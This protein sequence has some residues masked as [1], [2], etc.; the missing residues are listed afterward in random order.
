MRKL[1]FHKHHGKIKL[2]SKSETGDQIGTTFLLKLH[3]QIWWA[4]L[5]GPFEAPCILMGFQT[6][7]IE[8]NLKHSPL[9]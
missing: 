7:E 9:V 5:G 4:M 1:Q 8:T 2:H 3:L 6:S